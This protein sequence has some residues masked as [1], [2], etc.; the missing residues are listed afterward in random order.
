[1]IT[2]NDAI[3]LLL[4]LKEKGIDVQ[5]QI[6]ELAKK[7][8]VDTDVLKFIN[9]NRELDL[10]RFYEKIRKSYNNKKSNLYINIMKGLD[11]PEEVITTLNAYA[12]QI[13]LFAK[14]VETNNLITFYTFARLNEVYKVLYNYSKTFDLIPCMELI[15]LIKADI[16]TL[17]TIYR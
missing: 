11:Q 2:K 8:K 7:D 6:R 15:K 3:A 4:D 9:D 17:E 12:L 1:M 5:E 14:N 10:T 13:T 16:K